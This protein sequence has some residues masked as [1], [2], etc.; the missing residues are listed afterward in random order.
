MFKLFKRKIKQPLKKEP[1]LTTIDDLL[2][3]DDV[4]KVF[5]HAIADKPQIKEIIMIYRLEDGS[6]IFD[7]NVQDSI[8]VRGL[9]DY[10]H[11]LYVDPS[12]ESEE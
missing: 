3:S 7:T 5:N 11:D 6:V 10:S 1:E 4:N 9:L 12:I 8:T 2:S